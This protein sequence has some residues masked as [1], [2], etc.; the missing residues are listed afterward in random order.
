[1]TK[2]NYRKQCDPANPDFRLSSSPFYL[3]AHADFNY[4]KDMSV[5][6]MKYGVTK[7]MYRIMTVLREYEPSNIGFLADISLNKRNT[8]SRIVERMVSMGLA[9][10]SPNPED[11]RVT[12]VLLTKKGRDLLDTLTPI[13]GLQFLRAMKGVS[14]AEIR[15]LIETMQ[16]IV[17]N[18]EKLSI[19]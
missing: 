6:L 12:E 10:A 15:Q 5:V 3:M 9:N 16:K 13:V 14:N 7:S 11:S 1:M 8:T 18:L 17:S 2:I 19:E 4:H